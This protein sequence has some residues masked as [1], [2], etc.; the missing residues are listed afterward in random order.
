MGEC[1]LVLVSAA[2]FDLDIHIRTTSRYQYS[3]IEAAVIRIG[4]NT[5]E[6][7]SHGDYALDGI[8]AANL[9]GN[10]KLAQYPIYHS[11]PSEKRHVFDVVLGPHQ[12]ITLSTFKDLVSVKISEG[13]RDVFGD[14]VG[15]MGSFKGELLARDGSPLSLEADG[16]NAIGQEW[17]VL[18][19]EPMLFRTARAPFAGEKCILPSVE[20]KQR[21]LGESKLSQ[22][23]A[24][25][26]CGD[27]SGQ[28]FD[29]CV[30]DGTSSFL[31]CFDEI[32]FSLEIQQGS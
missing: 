2:E 24:E 29:N 18:E 28:Q 15:L 4:E 22:T 19:S 6:V 21:R 23:D 7:S 17:Q 5:L 30:F 25:R 26:A 27:F 14:S 10:A 9:T 3:Y 20:T 13:S 12:N 32:V 11:V 8:G 1:D 16:V 31:F